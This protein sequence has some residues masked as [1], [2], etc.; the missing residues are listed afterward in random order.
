MRVL[1]T[2]VSSFTGCWFAAALAESGCEV[3]ATTRRPCQGYSGV[4]ARRLELARRA[5][6]SLVGGFAFGDPRFVDLITASRVDILCHHGCEIGDFRSAAFNPVACHDA[7]TAGA[8]GVL[9]ALARGGGR[10]LVVT[11]SVFEGATAAERGPVLAYGRVKVRIRETLSAAA[12][13]E[14]LATACFVVPHPIGALE[15]PGFGT[16]LASRWLRGQPAC[17][18]H[19]SL[20][21][22]FVHV[23]LLG[24]LYAEFCHAQARPTAPRLRA[25]SGHAATLLAH[26]QRIAAALGPRLG[27][28]CG[29]VA[30]EPPAAS[31]EPE[32][33]VNPEP[34]GALAATW[35]VERA[36][37]RMAE[38][39]LWLNSS[40]S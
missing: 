35:P 40:T 19:P 14:G 12:A 1:L 31:D 28:P 34:A 30:A 13:R 23:D 9:A 38:F 10:A 26:A 22:D 33:L 21:R 24:A 32:I 39:Y 25:P 20:V 8:A 2:G 5:G 4:A 7:A 37:D 18:R 16:Y 11:G 6:C 27:I 29:V 3:I 36:W 17:V 15:K